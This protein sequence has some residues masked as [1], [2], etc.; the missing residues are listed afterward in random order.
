MTTTHKPDRLVSLDVFRG[1]TIMAMILVNNPGTWSAVYPPLRHAKWNGWTLTDLIFPFFLFIVGVSI[2]LAFTHRVAQG[3]SRLD[4]IS[5]AARRSA[6]LFAL[7]LLLAAYPIF[8]W[9]DT[10]GVRSG[11]FETIRMMGVLQRIAICYFLASLIYLFTRPRAQATLSGGLLLVYWALMTLVPVPGIGPG[12]LTDP[13]ANLAAFIDRSLLGEAHLWSGAARQWDPEGLLSTLPALATTLL[14]VWAGRLLSIEQLEALQKAVR[15]LVYGVFLIAT[16]YIWNWVFP[17]N[18][19][20]WSSSYA[21]FTAGLAMSVLGS[22]YWIVDIQK[23]RQGTR[24]FV[25]YGVNSITVFVLSGLL[26]RTLSL[27]EVPST[28]GAEISLQSW[29]FEKLFLT[30]ASPINASLLYA[31][32]WIVG[33]YAVL[34]LMYRRGVILKV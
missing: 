22:I 8:E 2:A 29:I 11:A 17:I 24:L 7:G 13:P 14:G 21:V 12:N 4:L 31:I 18:K 28:A 1:A 16:G 34:T 5:R 10:F 32:V 30:I 9:K 25:V 33:W 27:I 19:S 26:A 23:K 15:L 3:A 20:I 6:V